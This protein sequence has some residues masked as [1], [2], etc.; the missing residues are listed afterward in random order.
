M[1]TTIEIDDAFMTEALRGAGL[2]TKR[3]TV[4]LALET[5]VQ[6]QH[7]PQLLKL[8]GKLRWEGDLD[9]MRTHD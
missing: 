7:Q 1:R 4:H 6:L 9:A 8:K 5:L 2:K 3:A